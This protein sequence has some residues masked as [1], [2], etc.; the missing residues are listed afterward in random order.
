MEISGLDPELTICKIVVL[1]IKPYP[2]FLSSSRQR[3]RSNPYC[4]QSLL[5]I[6]LPLLPVLRTGTCVAIRQAIPRASQAEQP[7]WVGGFPHYASLPLC[8][9]PCPRL[10]LLKLS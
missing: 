2:L 9:A 3:G 7:L 5:C 8:L 10:H 6:T 4:S 1:P